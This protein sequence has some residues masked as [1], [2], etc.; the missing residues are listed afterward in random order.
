MIYASIVAVSPSMK[1]PP[2][3]E[4]VIEEVE[5]TE[6]IKITGSTGSGA[7]FKEKRGYVK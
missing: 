1:R 4:R 6:D 2:I 3:T 7:N 5:V